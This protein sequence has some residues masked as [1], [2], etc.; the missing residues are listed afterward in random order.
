M[1]TLP[2]LGDLNKTKDYLREVQQFH[3]E[4]YEKLLYIVS[5]TRQLQ[6]KYAYLGSL[7][8]D[9]DPM[10]NSPS[11]VNGYVLR[12]YNQQV[13]KLKDKQDNALL[14]QIFA[15]PYEVGFAKICLLILGRAPESLLGSSIIK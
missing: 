1:I 13:Q 14:N 15:D 4:F 3:P 8:K 9:K 7:I 11:N 5:L 6:F 2:S 10:D 12:L